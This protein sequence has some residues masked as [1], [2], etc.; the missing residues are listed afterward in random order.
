MKNLEYVRETF[1]FWIAYSLKN[2]NE[3]ASGVQWTTYIYT[4]WV[5]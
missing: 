1:N 5:I 3:I 4:I 2:K